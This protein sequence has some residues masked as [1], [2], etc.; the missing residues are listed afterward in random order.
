MN[1]F[2]QETSFRN[3]RSMSRLDFCLELLNGVDFFDYFRPDEKINVAIDK[4]EYLKNTFSSSTSND[5]T[6]YCPVGTIEFV[7]TFF[8]EVFGISEMDALPNPINVPIELMDDEFSGREM[9]ID[10]V[11]NNRLPENDASSGRY[12]VKSMRTI[13]SPS[14][15]M[16]MVSGNRVPLNDGLYQFSRLI[17]FESEWRF[18]IVKNVVTGKYD[19]DYFSNYSGNPLLVPDLKAVQ[20]MIDQIAH[21]DD[22]ALT[23]DVG[24]VNTTDGYK[25]YVVECHQIFSCGLYGYSNPQRY[26]IFLWRWYLKYKE[27]LLEKLKK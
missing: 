7:R 27:E 21:Y 1:F 3:W 8:S 24:I 16:I 10:R 25:T 13:K 19:I 23:L 15:G 22:D 12:F 18:F 4:L 9:F 5:L 2:V 26:P 11:E 6:N 14:N 17:D 20:K